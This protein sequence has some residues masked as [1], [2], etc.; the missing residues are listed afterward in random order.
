MYLKSIDET[1]N[2]VDGGEVA[3]SDG[4]QISLNSFASMNM[5]GLTR[6]FVNILEDRFVDFFKN[7]AGK[8]LTAEYLLPIIIGDL[9]REKKVEVKVLPTPD[10]WFGVTYKEDKPLVIESIRNLINNGVYSPDLYS[11]LL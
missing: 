9:L 7:I 1:S 10:S 4:N 11:D 6:D 3:I 2:I 8:E 5:W